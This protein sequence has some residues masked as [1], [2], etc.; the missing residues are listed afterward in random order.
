MSLYASGTV[1]SPE[2]SKAEIEAQLRRY[3]ATDFVSGQLDRQFLAMIGFRC[4]E[5]MVRF[6]LPLPDPTSKLFTRAR[7]YPYTN[8]DQKA[9]D[10]YE[11][12][13]RRRWR[14]LALVIKAKL[15]AVETGI[16]T[17]EHEFMAHIVM[18]DGKTVGQ[19]VGP[20]IEEAYR[21]GIVR[22]LLPEFTS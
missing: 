22:G 11:A 19:H 13:L 4:R 9:R 18:P 8:S 10:L 12:E 7:R 20:A 21:M 5:R 15:E 16:T 3:G 6:E 2:K 1:V 14:A 17:F